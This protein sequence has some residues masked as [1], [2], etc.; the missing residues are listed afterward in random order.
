MRNKHEQ[1]VRLSSIRPLVRYVDH[2]QAVVEI[3]LAL[4]DPLP[5]RMTSKRPVRR[6]EAFVEIDSADGFHDE[7]RVALDRRGDRSTVR[8]ELVRPA[9]WWPACMGGQDLYE[10][11]VRLIVDDRQVDTRHATIGLTSVRHP[12]GQRHTR[13]VV[14][15]QEC[16]IQHVMPIDAR[17]ENALLPVGGDSLI[18]VRGHYGPDVLYEAADRAGILLIQCVPIEASGFPEAGVATHIDRLSCHPC[19]AGWYVGHL[20]G[21]TERISSC[22]RSLDPTRMVFRE[23]G[24]VSAA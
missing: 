18:L 11:T 13:L 5:S 9:L 24:D 16:P 12:G 15:G 4:Q 22:L 17:D 23:L 6:L 7:E 21:M 19:L 14:N 3:N 1:P 10:L 2:D 8:F 20:G